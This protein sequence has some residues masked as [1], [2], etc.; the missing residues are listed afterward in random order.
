MN[1]NI[2]VFP[3]QYAMSSFIC[4]NTHKIRITKVI[5]STT[6]MYHLTQTKYGHHCNNNYELLSIVSFSVVA[7]I[8]I[9]MYKIS[10]FGTQYFRLIYFC[11]VKSTILNTGLDN[12]YQN[13]HQKSVLHKSMASTNPTLIVHLWWAI[14]ITREMYPYL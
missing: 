11:C 7:I 9:K 10:Y 13:H 12:V 3:I 4:G 8:Y 6:K 5:W 1:D 2:S 14:K